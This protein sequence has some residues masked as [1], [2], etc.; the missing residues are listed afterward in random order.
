MKITQEIIDIVF[1]L[2]DLYLS[3]GNKNLVNNLRVIV[4]EKNIHKFIKNNQYM[5]K[6]FHIMRS[7]ILEVKTKLIILYKC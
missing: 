6:L 2:I 5:Y 4:D 3:T 1:N 7:R